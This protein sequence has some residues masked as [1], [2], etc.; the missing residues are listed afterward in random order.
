M[1]E[2]EFYLTDGGLAI[3]VAKAEEPDVK[4]EDPP[5]LPVVKGWVCSHCDSRRQVLGDE[6]FIR[7]AIENL[8]IVAKGKCDYGVGGKD[9][10][11]LAKLTEAINMLAVDLVGGVPEEFEEFT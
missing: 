1:S 8:Y 9:P 11:R 10:E 5:E 6:H 2:G 3:P 4:Q 7:Y